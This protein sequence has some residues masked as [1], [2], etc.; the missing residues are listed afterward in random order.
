MKVILRKNTTEIVSGHSLEDTIA[1]PSSTVRAK[2]VRS[3]APAVWSSGAKTQPPGQAGER[4]SFT[5]LGS[6]FDLL[7]QTEGARERTRFA[8]TV[9]KGCT[10]TP[11][12]P[13]VNGHYLSSFP[14]T[15]LPAYSLAYLICADHLIIATLCMAQSAC[16][17]TV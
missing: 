1:C 10:N 15:V 6:L 7:D 9:D 8:Q 17:H 5:P 13:L 3:S 14:I 2:R 11:Q 16:R 12:C 4:L